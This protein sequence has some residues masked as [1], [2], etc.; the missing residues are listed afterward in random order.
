M[1]DQ[2]PILITGIP[3]SGA[4]MIA[5]A[6]NVCGTFSG[7]VSKMQI[8]SNIQD[9]IR[10][11]VDFVGINKN[12]LPIT[13]DLPI[14][15]NWKFKVSEILENEGYKQGQWIYKDSFSSLAWPLWN[16]AF[17]NAKWIIV[18]RKPI[19]I[20]NSCM[21]TAYMDQCNCE[22]GWMQWI[23]EYEKRFVEMIEAGLNCKQVWPER[24]VYGDYK[25]MYETLDWL[26]LEWKK[27]VVDLIEPMLWNSRQKERSK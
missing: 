6:I 1:I 23:K 10:N 17:P 26:G 12:E 18:R 24:M 16:Y 11:Y 19:D 8:N 22:A 13:K 3:R 4:S 5:A 9:L 14:L 15:Q 2:Q 25:Q 20:V 7:Q 27:E 21:K